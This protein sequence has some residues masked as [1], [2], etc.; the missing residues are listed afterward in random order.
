MDFAIE[1]VIDNEVVDSKQRIAL[2]R[3]LRCRAYYTVEADSNDKLICF[4]ESYDTSHCVH[5][6]TNVVCVLLIR[7]PS[8]EQVQIFVNITK[9]LNDERMY[10]NEKKNSLP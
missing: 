6:D 9:I 5:L 8:Y 10:V 3:T 2:T 7:E 1:L 4:L